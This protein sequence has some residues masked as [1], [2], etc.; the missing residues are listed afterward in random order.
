MQE[1]IVSIVIS[2]LIGL[3]VCSLVFAKW[4]DR[5]E[6]KVDE[7]IASAHL[8]NEPEIGIQAACEH[9]MLASTLPGVFCKCSKCGE[10]TPLS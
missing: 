4:A 5:L 9:N 3:V 1:W 8:P 10:E 6:S 7:L 2:I